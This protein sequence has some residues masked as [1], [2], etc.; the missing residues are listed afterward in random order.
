MSQAAVQRPPARFGASVVTGAKPARF[1]GFVEPCHPTLREEVP[2]GARWVHEIEFDGCRTQAH[3][4]N[5]R[6]AIYTRLAYDWTLR[7]RTIADA[8][9]A[10]AADDLILDGEAL[11]A[12]SR[13]V[14]DFGPLHADLA[15]GRKDRLLYYAFD[16]LY[17]DG[18]DLR[19]ARLAER[20]RLLPELLA[21]ASE[22]ILFAEHLEGDGAEIQE[23]AGPWM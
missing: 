5:G 21:D 6:P 13:G 17:L 19:G 3:L 20:K 18:F 8:L 15:A 1:P 9:A 14:P 7:F 12:D 10:L 16:L 23:R 2:A 4:R 11:V 22:R